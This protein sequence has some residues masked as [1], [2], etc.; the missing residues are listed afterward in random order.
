MELRFDTIL[1][2]SLGN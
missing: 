1:H 2:S